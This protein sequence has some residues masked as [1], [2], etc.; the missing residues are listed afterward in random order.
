MGEVSGKNECKIKKNIKSN[1]LKN[2]LINLLFEIAN[3][4]ALGNTHVTRSSQKCKLH[5]TS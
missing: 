3:A 4:H 2:V 1:V 5:R